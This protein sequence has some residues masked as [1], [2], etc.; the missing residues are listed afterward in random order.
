[1]LAITCAL[2]AGA[3]AAHEAPR[4]AWVIGLPNGYAMMEQHA[5]VIE[6]STED[7]ARAVVEIPGGSRLVIKTAAPSR[8]A[9]DFSARGALFKS[10]EIEA[11]GTVV[12]LG[13]RG[14]TMEQEQ[15]AGPRVV[16]LNYRLI[17][18]PG[19]TAGTY[20]F[21]VALTVRNMVTMDLQNVAGNRGR[22]IVSGLT[23][24]RSR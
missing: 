18:A 15:A 10:V 3:A 13:P 19:T 9:L 4:A 5:T 16:A 11:T 24:P 6:V 22:M 8:Y 20:A 12:A 2:E 23:E 7:V 1:M 21:P 17:L 14:G